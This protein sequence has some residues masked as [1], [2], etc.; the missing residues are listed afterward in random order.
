M[1]RLFEQRY[2][3]D[4][5]RYVY[6]EYLFSLFQGMPGLSGGQGPP[7]AKGD[8]GYPGQNGEPGFDGLQGDKV[9]W[10]HPAHLT[11]IKMSC[12]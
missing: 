1:R 5:L 6:F 2:L 4:H 12:Y 3:I 7:G 8:R 9:S 10:L 11:Y